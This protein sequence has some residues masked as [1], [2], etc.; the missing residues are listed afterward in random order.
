MSMAVGLVLYTGAVLM[1]G[2]A[3]LRAPAAA[4][5]CE[6]AVAGFLREAS[7]EHGV[8]FLRTGGISRGQPEAY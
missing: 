7:V 4:G 6:G 3:V 2:P 1:L 8:P 5:L